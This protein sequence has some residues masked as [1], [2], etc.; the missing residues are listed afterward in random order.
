LSSLRKNFFAACLLR[1]DMHENVEHLAVLV[2]IG[3]P[4]L[5]WQAG[6]AP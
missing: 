4:P 1:R 2:E 5:A 6:I 3:D